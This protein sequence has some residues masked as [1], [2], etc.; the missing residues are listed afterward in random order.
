MALKRNPSLCGRPVE[1]EEEENDAE[2]ENDDDDDD[3]EGFFIF[4][5][6]FIYNK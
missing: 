1:E 6:P 4:T 5:N 3:E 2:E